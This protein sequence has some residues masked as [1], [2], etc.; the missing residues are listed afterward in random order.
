LLVGDFYVAEPYRGSGL[1]D[2][3]LS[4]AAQ[5]ARE[6]GCRDV[7]LNVDVDNERALAFYEKQGF[8]PR[9]YRMSVGAEEL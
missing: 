3:L 1:A 5:R 7:E 8:E 6:A 4:R 9:R 2:D